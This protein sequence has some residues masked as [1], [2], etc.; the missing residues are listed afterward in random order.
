MSDM[1]TSPTLARASESARNLWQRMPAPVRQAPDLAAVILMAVAGLG[2]S[3]YLTTV[4]YAKV[5]LYCNTTG[6]INCAAVTTSRYSV[7]PFTQIPIT[8][9]GMLW[10]VVSGGLAVVALAAM[11]RGEVEPARLRLAHVAWG[12]LGLLFVLYLV[13]AEIVV[14]HQICEWCT[15]VHLLTLATFLVVANRWQHAPAPSRPAAPGR[16]AGTSSNAPRTSGAAGRTP[17]RG[18]R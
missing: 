14:L 12:A 4:H 16:R 11:A 17:Q 7:V 9:P 10:F 5:P 13:Y 3:V 6:I 18:R 2:I 8:I 1:S 15:V